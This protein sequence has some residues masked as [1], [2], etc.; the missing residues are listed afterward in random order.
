MWEY[1]MQPKSPFEDACAAYCWLRHRDHGTAD[2]RCERKG[3][4]FSCAETVSLILRTYNVSA[5]KE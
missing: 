2:L 5:M 3:E 4:C 1:P